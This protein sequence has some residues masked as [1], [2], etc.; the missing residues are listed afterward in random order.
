M[1]HL[2]FECP[3]IQSGPLPLPGPVP[4]RVATAA[5]SV[6]RR[7]AKGPPEVSGISDQLV[8]I[9]T[10]PVGGH[11]KPRSAHSHRRD[12]AASRWVPS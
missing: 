11:Q 4:T 12:L 8:A 6:I 1:R 2:Q 9:S 10:Q 3:G 5:F 7:F